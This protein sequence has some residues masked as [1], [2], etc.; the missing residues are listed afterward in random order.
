VEVGLQVFEVGVP[1]EG[2]FMGT[3]GALNEELGPILL[4]SELL[5]VLGEHLN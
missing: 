3:L 2:G 4:L 1:L 5:R